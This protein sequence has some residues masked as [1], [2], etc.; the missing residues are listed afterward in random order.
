MEND[1]AGLSRA[2]DARARAVGSRAR[3][4]DADM[5]VVAGAGDPAAV[6]AVT[7]AGHGLGV[8]RQV[9]FD[10]AR[11]NIEDANLPVL[12]AGDEELAIG[13]E[14]DT[15]D[16]VGGIGQI[17]DGLAGIGLPDLDLLVRAGT[18]DPLAV[19]AKGDGLHFLGV[20]GKM[21][22]L[23]AVGDVPDLDVSFFAGRDQASASTV[24]GQG[25]DGT[26]MSQLAVAQDAGDVRRKPDRQRR[27]RPSRPPKAVAS[28][29]EPAALESGFPLLGEGHGAGER[30]GR[31]E[32]RQTVLLRCF[33]FGVEARLQGLNRLYG[34]L[35]W[36]HVG[37]GATA[38]N[39]RE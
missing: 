31:I 32:L 21:S 1:A 28:L 8:A 27:Q 36:L 11:A 23:S 10:L 13:S 22:H 35:A 26:A 19:G 38:G 3:L 24:E 15:G 17:L 7:D 6:A 2:E 39:Q 37:R 25:V 4:P 18:G 12:T 5:G 9:V 16:D 30:L 14:A 34:Q 29:E 20:P 33:Q